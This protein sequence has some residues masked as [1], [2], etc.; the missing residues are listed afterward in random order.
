[1]NDEPLTIEEIE[2]KIFNLEGKPGD[3]NELVRLLKLRDSVL[4]YMK[5]ASD[6]MMLRELANVYKILPMSEFQVKVALNEI[7]RNPR[8]YSDY[9]YQTCGE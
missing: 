2:T 5:K 9:I 1:M 3:I 8:K 4:D 7:G 6:G